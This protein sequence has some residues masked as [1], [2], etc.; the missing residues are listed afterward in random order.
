ME[1]DLF[2][3]LGQVAGIGG[4]SLGVFLLLFRDVIRKK[5]FPQLTKEQAYLLLK[6]ISFYVWTVALAGIAAWLISMSVSGST[7]NQNVSGNGTGIIH[8]GQGDINQ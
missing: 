6:K 3:T 7:I 2:K 1:I 4:L 8:T 5:I